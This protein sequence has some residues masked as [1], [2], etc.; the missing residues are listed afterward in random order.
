MVPS[1]SE[2][3][4]Q[5]LH[6]LGSYTTDIYRLLRSS[7][8][9]GSVALRLG[10]RVEFHH[11]PSVVKFMED[12][13]EYVKGDIVDEMNAKYALLSTQ[14]AKQYPSRSLLFRLSISSHSMLPRS[15]TSTSEAAIRCGNEI[16][17]FASGHR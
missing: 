9:T 4:A 14:Q 2:R 10:H 16:D 17:Y 1:L 5:A 15:P 7:L 8:Y 13:Q 12:C 11:V 3:I 6:S